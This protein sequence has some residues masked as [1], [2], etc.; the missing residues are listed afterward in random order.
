MLT[1]SRQHSDGQLS[2]P[3]AQDSQLLGF[4]TGALAAAAVSSSQDLNQLVPAAV[5]AIVVALHTGLRAAHVALSIDGNTSPTVTTPWSM[6]VCPQT[7]GG[8]AAANNLAGVLERF[9]LQKVTFLLC[10]CHVH[11]R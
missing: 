3:T 10:T 11:R 7:G 4:C 2:Y 1:V 9:N 5:H 8:G 6:V